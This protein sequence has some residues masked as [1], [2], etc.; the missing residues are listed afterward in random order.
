MAKFRKKPVVVEA[1]R[2]E[3]QQIISTL[4]GD[5]IVSPGDWVITGIKGEK[6]PCKHDIFLETYERVDSQPRF[7]EELRH[8]LNKYCME[9]GGDTPDFVLSQYL[10][11]CLEAF[12]T[13]VKMRDQWFYFKPWPDLDGMETEEISSI[14]HACKEAEKIF[15]RDATPAEEVTDE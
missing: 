10:F 5:M 14:R 3:E 4:E 15:G 7:Q 9:N 6:Y 11:S 1:V 13:A 2:A 12:N 8:L